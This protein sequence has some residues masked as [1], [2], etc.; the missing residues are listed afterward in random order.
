LIKLNT[1]FVDVV[2]TLPDAKYLYPHVLPSSRDFEGLFSL[3]LPT[4][5]FIVMKRYRMTLRNFILT[6]KRENLTDHIL[7]G[8][9]MEAIVFLQQNKISHRDVKSD[10]VL[11]DFDLEDSVPHLVLSDFGSA[12]AT[13]S[14]SIPYR[15]EDEDLGGNVVLRAPEIRRAK[16]GPDVVLNFRLSD[17]WSAA[18]LAYEI[19][20]LVNPF[21]SALSGALYTET[22]LP[23]LPSRVHP[24]VQRVVSK[25]LR[26]EPKNRP[27]PQIAANVV[28]ISLFR[29]GQ[30]IK[31]FFE[32]LGLN[33]L[34][35]VNSLKASTSLYLKT[36]GKR[37][38]N[39][40]DGMTELYTAETILSKLNNQRL[41]SRAELQLRATFLS[42]IEREELWSSLDYFF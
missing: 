4:T 3:N 1:A 19:F 9:L 41:I 38:E 28:C 7:F 26:I 13:E 24:A 29:F 25:M 8:Q 33:Y 14:W 31:Q 6:Q 42:R 40:L 27:V 18:T 10:N 2:P 5:L 12:L 21:N 39:S 16:P 17:T 36:L 34:Q 11:L 32:R 15:N 20:T 30:D 35:N 22:D 23:P 37:L